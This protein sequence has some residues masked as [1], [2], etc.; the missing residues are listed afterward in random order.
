MILLCLQA[1]YELGVTP[2]VFF[3]AKIRPPQI[4]IRHVCVFAI[5]GKFQGG[6]GGST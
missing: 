5:L 2:Q 4:G 1:L 6:P 3:S